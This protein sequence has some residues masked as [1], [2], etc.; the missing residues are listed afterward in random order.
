V[1]DPIGLAGSISL[2]ALLGA[3]IGLERQWHQGLA[4]LRT[5]ALVAT[6]AAA[7][8]Q[9]SLQTA[10]A[11]SPATVVGNVISG[12]GFLGA[13]V[14]LREGLNVRGLNTA[15][16]LWG[17]ASVGAYAG[18]GLGLASTEITA[19]ILIINIALRPVISW[20]TRV[21]AHFSVGAPVTYAASVECLAKDHL[22]VRGALIE[23]CHKTGLR[24]QGI[25]S[26][27]IPERPQSLRIH[28]EVVGYGRVDQT[29][30]RL[31]TSLSEFDSVCSL[32][33]SRADSPETDI[34][35]HA[36]S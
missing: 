6:A 16:T 29:V 24:L 17:T 32:T 13:G 1:N 12:I 21:G 19:A 18:A 27:A 15:A 10:G 25:A 2:A 36:N 20:L 8:V 30:E 34:E 26:T 11:I 31:V 35:L 33:W 14:I 23:R 5:N 9:M 22:V 3:L 28:F 7:F 4:G